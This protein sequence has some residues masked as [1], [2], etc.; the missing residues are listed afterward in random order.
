[1]KNRIVI[2]AVAVILPVLY[3]ACGPT[4][5]NEKA[6]SDST[7]KAAES[8]NVSADSLT[9]EQI[10]AIALLNF[11]NKYIPLC[12]HTGTADKIEEQRNKICTAKCRKWLENEELD[13]DPFLNAQDCDPAWSKSLKIY[14]KTN[15]V[16]EVIY[17]ISP[18]QKNRITLYTVTENDDVRID[19]IAWPQ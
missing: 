15:G 9:Q 2:F 11:Y 6:V 18:D 16:F 12:S 13:F 14:P 5:T 7:R 19:S 10:T 17:E 4:R 3:N 1:M 8:S